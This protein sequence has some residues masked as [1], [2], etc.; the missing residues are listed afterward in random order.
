MILE[1]F[2]N[3]SK[4]CFVIA[5]IGQ[6][7]SETRARS[8]QI[9]VYVIKPA[10]EQF[11]YEA[12]R[13]D[14]IHQPGMITSQVIQHLIE[15]EL[16]IADLTG[17]NP[18]VYYELAIRHG[19]NKPVIHIKDVSESLPF[20]VVGIRT[21]DV[22]FRF[23]YSM[24]K[25]KQEIIKHIQTIEN[26]KNAFDNPVKFAQK[27]KRIEIDID[28]LKRIDLEIQSLK[29][30][31]TNESKQKENNL[32]EEYNRKIL[33]AIDDLPK[34]V[35]NYLVDDNQSKKRI[36]WVDDYPANNKSIMDVYR[37]QGV[38]IDLAL[39]TEQALD[40]L[41]KKKYDLI[42][43]DLGRRAEQGAG[44]KM[45]FE[46]KKRKYEHMNTCT[47]TPI[48]IYASQESIEKY[49]KSAFDAGASLTTASARDLV[50]KINEVLN[51][52]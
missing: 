39:D 26:D 37:H 17:Q 28:E 49:G 38:E 16:A 25:C 32:S 44:I 8:D 13:G 51:F 35:T 10:V 15:D 50:L 41:D 33:E 34:K 21:I 36:L 9:F 11:G 19:N 29:Q 48:F 24:E 47:T 14:H 7:N 45:I 2:A 43:S 6:E 3:M 31:Q 18:N 4:R 40:F 1:Y 27:A 20:D 30:N 52:N 22:D 42:I 23:I 5:P 12:I 46:I